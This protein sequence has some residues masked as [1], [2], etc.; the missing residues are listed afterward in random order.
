[1][2]FYWKMLICSVHLMHDLQF[3][4]LTYLILTLY[5]DPQFSLCLKQA[6]LAPVTL[7]DPSHPAHCVL[8]G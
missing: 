2:W 7:R 8:I 1:M 4:K 6:I 3:K 5:E